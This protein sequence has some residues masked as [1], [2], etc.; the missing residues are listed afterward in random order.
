MRGQIQYPT[1]YNVQT[2]SLR[3]LGSHLKRCV[4]CTSFYFQTG[5][6]TAAAV[7]KLI[8]RKMTEKFLNKQQQQLRRMIIIMSACIIV[9]KINALLLYS[10]QHSF[11]KQQQWRLASQLQVL[12]ELRNTLLLGQFG[13]F[14]LLVHTI[15]ILRRLTAAHHSLRLDFS[16]YSVCVLCSMQSWFWWRVSHTHR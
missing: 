4:W 5:A 16:S 10:L 12:W 3:H 15:L 14:S 2:I 1:Y 8:E 11:E 7:N 9:E 6:I 13:S